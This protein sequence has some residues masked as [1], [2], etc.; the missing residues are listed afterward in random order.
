MHYLDLMFW[1]CLKIKIIHWFGLY[2]PSILNTTTNSLY[3][4]SFI[5]TT[6]HCREISTLLLQLR[7]NLKKELL[8]LQVETHK[9]QVLNLYT[10]NIA[11]F[12]QEW[13]YW[14]SIIMKNSTKKLW[15]WQV[16]FVAN[17]SNKS[18]NIAVCRFQNLISIK[19]WGPSPVDA[20]LWP[21]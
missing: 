9:E 17:V 18:P 20:Q 21:A 10:S 15:A 13:V 2:V 16:S 5:H 19:W 8:D 7:L 4:Q 3:F 11:A 6:L 14:K 1:W 12:N